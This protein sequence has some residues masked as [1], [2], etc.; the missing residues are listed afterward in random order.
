MIFKSLSNLLA[1]NGSHIFGFAEELLL[2]APALLDRQQGNSQCCQHLAG[3]THVDT[4]EEGGR[5]LTLIL[6]LMSLL[7]P[8]LTVELLTCGANVHD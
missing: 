2:P 4:G 8:F 6:P 7:P 1:S 3:L 5:N